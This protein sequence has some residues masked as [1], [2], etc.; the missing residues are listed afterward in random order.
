MCGKGG[1]GGIFNKALKFV[2]LAPEMPKIPDPAQQQAEAQAKVDAQ[3]AKAKAEAD[4]KFKEK[5]RAIQKGGRQSTILAGKV[6]EAA[7]KS[8]L[9]G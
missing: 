5:R 1:L 4:A 7:D 9:G 6:E 3:K 2:G 8:K